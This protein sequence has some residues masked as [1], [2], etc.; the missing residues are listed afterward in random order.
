[1]WVVP[2][3]LSIASRSGPSVYFGPSQPQSVLSFCHT[4]RWKIFGP[5]SV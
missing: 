4:L 2:R 3:R 1:M 5:S